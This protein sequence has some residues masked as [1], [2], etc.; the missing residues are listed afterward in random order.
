MVPEADWWL[1]TIQGNRAV[2][3]V[4]DS[5]DVKK[6]DGKPNSGMTS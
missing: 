6:P 1:T 5:R 3:A 2:R 4:N